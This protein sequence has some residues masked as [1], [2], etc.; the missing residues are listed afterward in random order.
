VTTFRRIRF[1]GHRHL[2]MAKKDVAKQLKRITLAH[3]ARDVQTR[4]RLSKHFRQSHNARC[5]AVWE[6]YRSLP[7]RRRRG[8]KTTLLEI[9][10]VLS[11]WSKS[12]EE[13]VV[14]V[15]EKGDDDYRLVVDFGIINRARQYLVQ[16]LLEATAVLQPNQYL[17]RGGVPAAIMKVADLMMQD[18]GYAL[19]TDIVSCYPS[20]RAEKMHTVLP[21]EKEVIKNVIMARDYNMI[22][23]HSLKYLYGPSDYDK[24]DPVTLALKLEKARCGMPHGSAV[25]AL[26][27]E[28][29]MAPVLKSLPDSSIGVNY[30]DNT[31]VMA[32]TKDAARSATETM[33][34]ALKGH[35]IGSLTP[36]LQG[37]Y[38]P[39]D[40][41]IFL[42]HRLR[43]VGSIVVFKPTVENDAKFLGRLKRDMKG[44]RDKKSPLRVRRAHARDL[45][46]FVQSWTAS[47]GLC[48][49]IKQRRAD[50]LARIAN[51]LGE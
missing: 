8:Q 49:G 37:E 45:R 6:A 5:V 26:V 3:T 47:F 35:P 44:V 4:R 32:K 36:S 25:A 50:A 23:G 40:D 20:F 28:I 12:D 9:A 31:L 18:Y 33:W 38:G 27:A 19:E 15:R 29:V 48:Q 43:K 7:W 39:G 34:S 14:L 13:A 17:T 42:G 1:F 46:Q 41:V 10:N 16:S 2:K 21:I 30:A 11:V 22:P 24:G 51:A